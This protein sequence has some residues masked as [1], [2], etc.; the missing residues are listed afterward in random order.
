MDSS[1]PV[2]SQRAQAHAAALGPDLARRA[3][4]VVTENARVLAAAEALRTGDL[5][6]TGRLMAASHAS[7]RGDY[8]VSGPELDAL[9]EIATGAGALGARLTGAGLGGC[10]VSLVPEDDVEAFEHTVR[11]QYRARTLRAADVFVV[12]ENREAGV[13]TLPETALGVG[14]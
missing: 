7:L 3:R 13:E 12:R 2:S 8:E 6:A 1:A 9:V 5:V 4:H 11:T 14:S 10:T